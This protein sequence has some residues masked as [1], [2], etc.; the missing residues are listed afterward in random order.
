MKMGSSAA[1]A[2]DVN[3]ASLPGLTKRFLAHSPTGC[4]HL[5]LSPLTN[6][7][8]PLHDIGIIRNKA[9]VRFVMLQRTGVIPEIDVAQNTEVLVRI[10]KIGGLCDSRLITDSGFLK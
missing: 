8:N 9:A 6:V 1:G 3:L 7:S 10:L 5:F 4:E 2:T